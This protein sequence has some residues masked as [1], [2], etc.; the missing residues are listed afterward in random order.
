MK[1]S[2]LLKIKY[3]P[4]W[5]ITTLD[6]FLTFVAVILSFLL[7]FNFKTTKIADA[8]FLMSLAIITGVFLLC[9][10][11]FKPYKEII[12]HTTI[13]GVLRILATTFIASTLLICLN[14]V[15]GAFTEG[16]LLVPNSVIC[17]NFFVAFFLLASIRIL[18]KGLFFF[19]S[20]S[21]KKPVIIV[22]AGEL[23]RAA[24]N[25]INKE[26]VSEW[27]VAAVA[28]DDPLKIGK[29]INGI[30]I[31]AFKEIDKF[32]QKKPVDRAI[33]AIHLITLDRRNEIA[34]F[35]VDKGIMVSMLPSQ[36]VND[37]F[38]IKRLRDVDI[39][40]LLEREPIKMNNTSISEK[41]TGKRILISGAA[42]SIGSEIVRQVAKFKPA[43]L[44]LLDVAESPLHEISLELAENYAEVNNVIFIGN[45]C[46]KNRMEFLFDNY[47]PSLVFHA[48]AYKHVPMMEK[49]PQEAVL[50]N[51]AGT[52]NLADLSVKYKAERFVMVSTDKAVNP[53]NVMGASKRAA[54]IYIQGLQRMLKNLYP[55]ETTTS[56]IT[57]RF[58]NVLASNGSVIPRFKEQIKKGGPITVTHP[59]ITRFFMT[60]PE[61]CQLVLEAGAMGNGGEIFVFDMGQSIRIADL[62]TKMVSLSGLKLNTD[63]KIVYSGL[64]P[65]EKLYEEVLNKEELTIATYHPKIKIARVA[66]ADL[67]TAKKYIEDMINAAK[68]NDDWQC[69]RLLKHLVPEFKSNNSKYQTIDID[70]GILAVGQN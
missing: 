12:R 41:L 7:R 57:T 68:N 20:K 58:G 62:A 3:M 56:F 39:E 45:I 61:A 53:T 40:D 63:I 48:A 51:I 52:R 70:R 19:A 27:Y 60:I 31:I 55:S 42:G 10:F 2:D 14:F 21:K 64:R 6:A 44:I 37:P 69:V 9:F 28:D 22:G 50:N 66:A 43:M 8:T 32:L 34:N 1:I 13:Q 23:G 29:K 47:K 67:D 38:K 59:D 11:I 33:I 24:I 49:H 17:I 46:D 4:R 30:P 18:I 25:S 5:I 26:V 16:S 65:G 54:E 36:W 15:Y 35:F